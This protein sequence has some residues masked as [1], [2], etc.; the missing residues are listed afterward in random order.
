[1]ANTR[2]KT[3]VGLIGNISPNVGEDRLPT[4]RIVLQHFYYLK[5]QNPKMKDTHII[6]CGIQRGKKTLSCESDC[7]CLL[8]KVISIYNKAGIPI[9]RLDRAKEKALKLISVHKTLCKLRNRKTLKEKQKREHFTQTILNELFDI[10]PLEVESIIEK[11]RKRC[12]K[13]KNEDIMFIKDQRGPRLMRIG[14][15]DSRYVKAAKRKQKKI[16]R[17]AKNDDVSLEPR[18]SESEMSTDS[19]ETEVSS[20]DA[21]FPLTSESD[22]QPHTSTA[23]VVRDTVLVSKVKHVSVR[24]QSDIL[25]QVSETMRVSNKGMS[26]SNV[27]RVGT[28]VVQ[29]AAENARERIKAKEGNDMILHFD[30]KIV[31]EYTKGKSLK[32]GRLAL[33]VN[34]EGEN[35]LLA[36]PVCVNSSGECQTDV[37]V[38]VLEFY[39]LKDE[40][41]GLVFDT[42][43]SNTGKEKGVCSRVSEFL[44]RPL[45]YLACR[46]HIYECHI[47][48][49]SKIFRSTCGPD[50][51]LFTKLLSEFSK[52]EIDRT[53]LCKYEY[54]KSNHLDN[55]AKIS[56]GVCS[57]LLTE[58]ML[59]RGDYR[60]LAELVIFY[61]S[62]EDA[63]IKI[64]QP[65][66][67][68][69]ARFMAQSIYYLKLK[70]LSQIVN[71][72]MS[73]AEKKEIDAM[74]EFI[75]LYYAKWFLT[76]SVTV[77]S[78]RNDLE[79]VW[80][81]KGYK[82][83]NPSIASKCL[84][85]MANHS[86]YLH[87]TMI[88][89]SML[90]DAV[91]ESE[92]KEIA[93]KILATAS[94]DNILEWKYEKVII[95]NIIDTEKKPTLGDFV[96]SRS[97]LIFDIL[98][99]DKIK[100]EWLQLPPNLWHLITAYKEFNS[101]VRALP[102]VNDSAERNIRL[103][104][105]F[106]L[107]CHDE[108]LR[109]DLLLA[110]DLKRKGRA[111]GSV[112]KKKKR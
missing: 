12:M 37:I 98:N 73:D 2:S 71:I 30:G 83:Y 3:E 51:P 57:M 60:E 92:K 94:T 46:H 68:H 25:Q 17:L 75:S 91:P 96:D 55:A 9:I 34:C 41:K 1:M 49:V 21:D 15:I 43:A 7:S 42:T 5:G 80:D 111:R 10:M 38:E 81:M 50:N 11:D 76:S 108:E 19:S 69:H 112:S 33:S 109:Q 66:A 59:P 29:E 72:Q 93:E 70:I 6:C 54:G 52:M 18:S 86:W 23:C 79:A 47:K 74:A 97:K 4:N 88:P 103:I 53:K 100:M 31:K 14:G 48:N 101:F 89:L 36:I 62:P 13:D 67:V 8:S 56:L 85:S 63:K 64:R 107:S 39:G 77:S 32:R 99:F 40:I 58:G 84:T 28:K 45:L 65:G 87:P 82:K 102:V 104:Q 20:E 44:K 35:I 95:S 110:V 90:D 78:P 26:K 106:V 24:A 22:P 16:A 61:L 105:D 27:H